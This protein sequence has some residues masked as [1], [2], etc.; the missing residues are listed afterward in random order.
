MFIGTCISLGKS[1]RNLIFK[2]DIYLHCTEIKFKKNDL[3][4]SICTIPIWKN[5][6]IL[7]VMFTLA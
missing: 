2:F 1:L 4:V 5:A 7:T 3:N 6:N